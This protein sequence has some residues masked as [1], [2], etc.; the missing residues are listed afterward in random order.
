MRPCELAIIAPT[1]VSI[2]AP[3]WGATSISPFGCSFSLFQSTHPCGVRPSLSINPNSRMVF[4][5]THP[6]GVRLKNVSKPVA[7]ISFN[8]RTRVGCDILFT[9]T[10]LYPTSFNPRTRVGCDEIVPRIT[11]A[12]AVSIHAPVWGATQSLTG[13]NYQL[14]EFQ[15]THPCGVRRNPIACY[16][17]ICFNPRTR[18]G[19]D[20]KTR[21]R[22][23]SLLRFNPRTRVGC[24]HSLLRISII[25]N[26]SIH[27]P[28]WGATRL[29]LSAMA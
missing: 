11:I 20:T 19:C 7:S 8:P 17:I 3:V 13:I 18:V 25:I 2:H 23:H 15:S 14:M 26:V 9:L 10:F 5:S 6:C 29:T 4:Q 27:A 12:K 28:V 24:D 1:K 16:R 22:C 21:C